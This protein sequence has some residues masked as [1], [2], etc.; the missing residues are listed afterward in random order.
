M[1]A[2]VA[3]ATKAPRDRRAVDGDAPPTA[4]ATALKYRRRQPDAVYRKGHLGVSMLVFA[5]LGYALVALS[6]PTLALLVG[7]TMLWLSMLPD[8]D[9]RIPGVSH[10]GVTHTLL[11]AVAVG[12]AFAVAGAVLA[13]AGGSAAGS[14]APAPLAAVGFGI[15]AV[16]VLAHL[17]GDV[18]TPAGVALFWPLSGRTY[19]LSVVR[20]DS[21]VGNLALFAAGVFAAAASLWLS[22]AP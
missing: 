1:A 22:L 16:T 6:Y 7:G 5:P 4:A 19:S 14:L 13:R 15:G 2:L 8:V 11:F 3:G 9:H 20:A 17:L 18:L 10:R 12:A 21:T